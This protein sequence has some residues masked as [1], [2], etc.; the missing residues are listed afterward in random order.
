MAASADAAYK[1]LLQDIYG[2]EDEYRKVVSAEEFRNTMPDGV[3]TGDF[4]GWRG[5]AKPSGAG[6]VFA[7]GALIA[8]KHGQKD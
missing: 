4:M 5:F 6:W 3:L 1:S 2:H 8:A 7:R